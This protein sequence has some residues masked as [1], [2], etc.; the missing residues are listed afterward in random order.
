MLV[1]KGI[2]IPERKGLLKMLGKNL[3]KLVIDGKTV[4]IARSTA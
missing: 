1:M 4:W 3:D 2:T